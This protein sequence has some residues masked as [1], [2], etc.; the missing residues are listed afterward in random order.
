MQV[1]FELFCKFLSFPVE[2]R[3]K[4][5]DHTP[6]FCAP[7]SKQCV[8]AVICR[9]PLRFH[10][11]SHRFSWNSPC[12]ACVLRRTTPHWNGDGEFSACFVRARPTFSRSSAPPF[13]FSRIYPP[14]GSRTR[15]PKLS[16]SRS[17]LT[18]FKNFVIIY[19]ENERKISLF[20]IFYLRRFSM[21]NT[22]FV[23]HFFDGLDAKG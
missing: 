2:I 7:R 16:V 15:F 8:S 4:Q 12:F 9:V 3:W 6:F 13:L 21:K 5:S 23:T 1:F 14:S 18:F 11:C 19:I 20:K 17:F 22:N 10:L